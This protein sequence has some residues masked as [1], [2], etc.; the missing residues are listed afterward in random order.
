M[1][2]INSVEINEQLDT[3]NIYEDN[4]EFNYPSEDEEI[5]TIDDDLSSTITNIESY[6]TEDAGH[7]EEILPFTLDETALKS[8]I[9]MITM[10]IKSIGKTFILKKKI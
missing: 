6:T 1:F 9:I 7:D 4:F 2:N 3:W 5:L 8:Y 10:K